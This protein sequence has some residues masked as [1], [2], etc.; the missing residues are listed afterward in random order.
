ALDSL[1]ET[2]GEMPVDIA[3]AII[4]ILGATLAVYLLNQLLRT[5]LKGSS[6]GAISLLTNIVRAVIAIIV[7]FFLGENVFDIQ[8]SGMVQALGVTTLVV[9]LGLQDLIKSVVAGMLIVAGNIVSVGDQ[10]I[11]GEH[12]GVVM[13]INW[14]QITLRDRDGI[15]HVMPNSKIMSDNFM[16]VTGKMACRHMFE[17]DIA[18]G[19]NLKL[20][21]TDI[22]AIAARVLTQRGWIAPG[23]MPQVVFIGSSAFGS[24][25]SVRIFISDIEY[26]V[27]SMDAVMCEISERGYLADCTH[28]V[29]PGWK[30]DSGTS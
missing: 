13:D 26:A 10:V 5:H 21:K 9:S 28:E 23:Y 20:V 18:P 8:M 19:V 14:H 12:R 3:L 4:T 6:I 17:C 1:R 27:R 30:R 15:P 29:N 7:V 16:R 24:R 2:Y 22:E 25:A 11:M